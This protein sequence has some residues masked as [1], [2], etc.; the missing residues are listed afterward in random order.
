MQPTAQ[1][2]LPSKHVE[3][4]FVFNGPNRTVSIVLKKFT[5]HFLFEK[6]G[7]LLTVVHAPTRRQE[8]ELSGSCLFRGAAFTCPREHLSLFFPGCDW[9]RVREFCH[10]VTV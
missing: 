3:M 10:L 1:F 2:C 9:V 7:D 4:H 5:M 6:S 8:A